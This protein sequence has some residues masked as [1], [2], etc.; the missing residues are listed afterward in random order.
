[1]LIPKLKYIFRYNC[2]NKYSDKN[3]KNFI[4]HIKVNFITGEFIWEGAKNKEGYGQFVIAKYNKS[5][6]FMAHRVGYEMATGK[7][8]L[9]NMCVCHKYDNPSDVNPKHLFLGTRLDNNRDRVNKGR[10]G[11]NSGEKQGSSKLIKKEVDEMRHKYNHNNYM[12]KQLAD[13]YNVDITCVS[14]IICNKNWNDSNY[15]RVKFENKRY[16][17]LTQAIADEIRKL[18]KTGKY[19]QKQLAKMFNISLQTVGFIIRNKTWIDSKIKEN[20][21]ER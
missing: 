8:I 9:N 21:I 5:K 1:M 20:V 13:E 19:L 7:I 14:L 17:K 2:N 3:K 18:Y 6:S 16:T 15:T 10:N 4:K 11:N 12:M